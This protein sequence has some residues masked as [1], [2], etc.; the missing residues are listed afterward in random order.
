MSS[1]RPIL[2]KIWSRRVGKKETFVLARYQVSA[3]VIKLLDVGLAVFEEN[4]CFIQ[5]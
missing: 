2:D 5:V 1:I 3:D 4:C